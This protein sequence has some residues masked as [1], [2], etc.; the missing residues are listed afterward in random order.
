MKNKIAINLLLF[1]PEM[2]NSVLEELSYIQSLGYDGVEIP[3]F[4]EDINFYKPWKERIQKLGLSAFACTITN[5]EQNLISQDVQ[6]RKNGLDFLKKAVDIA[7]F[8][9]S[10]Y[11]SGPF[12]SG[13]SVFS[14]KPATEQEINWAV[15]NLRELAE[16]AKEK[17][18]ILGIEYLNR[19]ES[20][21]VSSADELY[22][23]IKKINHSH[24]K[25]MFDTFHANI[26][27]K[28]TGEAIERIQD[29]MPHIQ[30]SE[31]TRGIL[32]EGQ[33][34]FDSVLNSLK[35]IDYQ[36]WIVIEAFSIKLVAANIWRKMFSS[37][38]ELMEKSLN[39]LKNKMNNKL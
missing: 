34:D 3:I 13:I 26:E 38:R 29:E 5:G 22:S 11:L 7:A 9:G 15:E 24:A 14:G 20:Y 19:F 33:V 37:E 10:P 35:K 1:G 36:G 12:H 2:D 30:L 17:G 27:E 4:N 16:Y 39:F 28:N 31:S 32:G 8:L 21:L 18:I 25:I 6:I 23:L